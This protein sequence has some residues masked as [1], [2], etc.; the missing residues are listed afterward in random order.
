ME[1]M[2]GDHLQGYDYAVQQHCLAVWQLMGNPKLFSPIT[3]GNAWT[4]IRNL[5]V[6]RLSHADKYKWRPIETLPHGQTVLMR[7]SWQDWMTKSKSYSHPVVVSVDKNGKFNVDDA[8]VAP[9][10]W[11]PIPTEFVDDYPF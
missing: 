8:L 9:T 4:E 1:T 5:L 2:N 10:E 11:A 3:S 7:A 6:Q